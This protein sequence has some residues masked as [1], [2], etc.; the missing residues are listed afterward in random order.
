MNIAPSRSHSHLAVAVVVI[1]VAVG[2]FAFLVPVV[3]SVYPISQVHQVC[4]S[5]I[6]MCVALQP[7]NVYGS[8]TYHLFGY[9]GVVMSDHAY[10]LITTKTQPPIRYETGG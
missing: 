5:P 8:V 4:P 3:P 1:A 7:P 10:L 2:L 6:S 9:G